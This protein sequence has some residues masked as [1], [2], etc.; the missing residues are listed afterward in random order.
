MKTVSILTPTY[1][2]KDLLPKLYESLVNQTD[3]DFVWVI[4]DD[5]SSDGT[6]EVVK[7]FIEFADFEIIYRKKKNGGKHTA[8]NFGYQYINSPLT[9]IVDSDDYLT[10]D[11]IAVIKDKYSHYMLEADLCGLSF[12]RGK[13]T[14]GYLSDSGVPIDGLKESYVKCRVN[15]EIGGDI[16]EVWVTRCLK[17][18]PFPEFSGEKFLGEDVVW[19]KMSDKYKLRYFNK[20]IY[21]SNY[22]EDGLTYNRRKYNIKSPLGCVE[23]AKVFLESESKL[24]VKIIAMLQY[25]IYGRFANIS[26][27]EL[28]NATNYRALFTL[29]YI[30]AR[31]LWKRW[32]K[33]YI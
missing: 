31:I 14:G 18:F 4:I 13:P 2:R 21:I 20:V 23:R 28:F 11:A 15:R 10:T 16:A 32:S 33:V 27:R 19:I 8:L 24:K 7:K 5:G 12:L 26:G 9:F 3:K 29:C 22:R 1:N 30:P 25:Q 6:E 17:E